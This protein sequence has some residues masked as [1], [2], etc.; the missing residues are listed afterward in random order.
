LADLRQTFRSLTLPDDPPPTNGCW[1]G[2]E[3]H[4]SSSI[5]R[6]A[7]APRRGASECE[8]TH[9]GS[10]GAFLPQEDLHTAPTLPAQMP[11][12]T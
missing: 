10:I 11:R 3:A 5:E 7:E 6:A 2:S 4:D 9:C 1:R 8:P 12:A